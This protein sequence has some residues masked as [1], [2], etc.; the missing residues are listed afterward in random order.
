[1]RVIEDRYSNWQ[2]KAF[3]LENLVGKEEKFDE[4]FI[5]II[6]SQPRAKLRKGAASILGYMKR[7][8]LTEQLFDQIFKENEWSVRFPLAKSFGKHLG[9][10]AIDKLVEK[11][12]ELTKIS[13]D[14]QK[15]QMKVTLTEAIGLMGLPE[16]INILKAILD[17]IGNSRDKFSIELIIQCIYSIGEI[18]DKSNIEYLLRY[19]AESQYST[20]LIRNSANHAIEKIAKK[21]G[22]SSKKALLEELNKES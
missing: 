5:N 20:E 15:H 3:Y 2:E 7:A 13:T 8:D 12:N 19:S 22:F 6:R 10:K 4:V 11:Y 14:A 1:M 9:E 18:G 17:E 16:G 21:Y